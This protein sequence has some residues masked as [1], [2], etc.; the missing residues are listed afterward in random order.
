[1][2]PVLLCGSLWV[3]PNQRRKGYG[4]FGS[5]SL[6]LAIERLGTQLL[7]VSCVRCCLTVPPTYPPHSWWLLLLHR[8]SLAVVG[9][10]ICGTMSLK[11]YPGLTEERKRSQGEKC[12][13][14]CWPL[15]KGHARQ[16]CHD[17]SV[18]EVKL[19]FQTSEDTGKKFDSLY[20]LLLGAG[21]A[22]VVPWLHPHCLGSILQG[23]L[24]LGG[25]CCRAPPNRASSC[26][27][28]ALPLFC[29]AWAL[30]KR[31]NYP[32]IVREGSSKSFT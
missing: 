18:K 1:M 19:L 22:G 3:L 20:Q 16:G 2:T 32:M 7:N 27:S 30:H 31:I 25:C 11:K 14:K 13:C 15:S 9:Q 10:N 5:H 4:D 12:K 29:M 8:A 21:R 6:F 28:Q 17:G 24:S 26:W 23:H